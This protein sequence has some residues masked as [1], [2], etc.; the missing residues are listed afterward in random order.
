MRKLCNNFR[1]VGDLN[2]E[3]ETNFRDI[4]P[5]ELGLGKV[6]TEEQGDTFSDLEIETRNG[7][8]QVRF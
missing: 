6:N 5:E 7:N 3:F 1:F 2:S 4:Y 8:F